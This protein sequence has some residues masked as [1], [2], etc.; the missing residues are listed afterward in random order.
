MACAGRSRK[1][2]LKRKVSRRGK[3]GEKGEGGEE[4]GGQRGGGRLGKKESTCLSC[5]G[6]GSYKHGLYLQWN[7][8]QSSRDDDYLYFSKT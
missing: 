2:Y 8:M 7:T 6:H 4:Q 3:G 5:I 1:S